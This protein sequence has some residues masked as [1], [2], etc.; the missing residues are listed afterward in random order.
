MR[1]LAAAIV[2]V[3]SILSGLA[4]EEGS[5]DA[6]SNSLLVGVAA[7]GDWKSDAPGTR[8][9]IRASDLPAP[10]ATPSTINGAVVVEKPGNARLNV[11][12]GSKSNNLQVDWTSRG[13][14]EWLRMATYSS[15]NSGQG[16]FGY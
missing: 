12:S 6:R 15:P 7:Y 16:A 14:F 3:M 4:S 8:R 2:I 9:Y 5:L 13:S 11:P 10:Y 1:V